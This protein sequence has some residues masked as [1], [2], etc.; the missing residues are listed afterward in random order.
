MGMMRG[1]FD[2]RGSRAEEKRLKEKAEEV[3][4]RIGMYELRGSLMKNLP[5]G[6]QKISEIGRAMMND[7]KL[8][9]LDEPAAGL[10]PSERAELVDV[11]YKGL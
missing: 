2:I 4:K 8:I 10:N 3:L 5:Y 7:P 1:I 9:L 11:I 6:R